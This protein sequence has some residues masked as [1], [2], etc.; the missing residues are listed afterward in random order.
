MMCNYEACDLN[1]V[2]SFGSTPLDNALM[3]NQRAIAALLEEAGGLSGSHPLLATKAEEEKASIRASEEERRTKRQ[4]EV[5]AGLPEQTA[6]Q[7]VAT[8]VHSQTQFV[9]VCIPAVRMSAIMLFYT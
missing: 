8:V 1:P 2:D 6:V 7:D 9:Q 5:L 3:K 4:E